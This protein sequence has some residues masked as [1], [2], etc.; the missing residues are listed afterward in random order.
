MLGSG[1]SLA[2]LGSFS[3]PLLRP[4][5]GITLVASFGPTCQSRWAQPPISGAS[6]IL[7]LPHGL[8]TSWT[9]RG[10]CSFGKMH[11][12]GDRLQGRYVGAFFKHSASRRDLQSQAGAMFRSISPRDV[13]RAPFR[14]QDIHIRLLKKRLTYLIRQAEIKAI[15]LAYRTWRGKRTLRA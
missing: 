4:R 6:L 15:D 1:K 13:G 2:H 14:L 9:R 12:D 8:M 5:P 3:P 11:A 7:C 10:I